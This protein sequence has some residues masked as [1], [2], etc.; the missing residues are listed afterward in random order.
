MLMRF[1]FLC[2]CLC[3]AVPA[4]AEDYATLTWPDLLHTLVRFNALNLETDDRLLDDY[5]MITDCDLYRYYYKDDF[6]WNRL[7]AL[8]R[9]SSAKDS[10]NYPVRYHYDHKFQL[11][12][13]DFE[14]KI[15]RFSP[16][17]QIHNIGD[18]IIFTF[19]GPAC[20][21]LSPEYMPSSF[22]AKFNKP[23]TIPGLELDPKTTEALLHYMDAAG[24][25]EHY[26]YARFNLAIV[27]IEP[28]RKTPPGAGDT[29]YYQSHNDPGALVI[30]TRIDS[31]Q[32]FKDP[33]MTQLVYIFTPPS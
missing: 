12:R 8:I 32:F 4:H 21:N 22:K 9:R 13:Y 31:V 26:V 25:D 17:T 11:D 2:L 24:N 19:A 1:A 20:D 27:Y 3:F 18:I 6:K 30:D 16:R 14:T 7:R 23:L 5:A 10:A 15:Y 28:L 33:D 29:P